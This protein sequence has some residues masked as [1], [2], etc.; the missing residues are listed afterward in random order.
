LLADPT[1]TLADILLYHVV[2]AKAMSTDLSDGQTISTLL[3]NDITVTINGDGVFIN[4]VKV[5]LADIEADNGVVHVIDAVLLP[6]T[7]GILEHYKENKKALSIYPNPAT[8]Y[9]R[10]SGIDQERN[11]NLKVI[12]ANGMTVINSMLNSNSDSLSV[13]G[14]PKGSYIVVVMADS[15]TYTGK[16]LVK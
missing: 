11:V 14:L 10:I 3:S 2:G 8:D 13:S 4:S 7:T 9:V 12:N 5:T 6:Q 1:G 15:E 16:L